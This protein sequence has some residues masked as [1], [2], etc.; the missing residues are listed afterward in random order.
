MPKQKSS[1]AVSV[2]EDLIGS[3]AEVAGKT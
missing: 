1:S 2:F 3:R